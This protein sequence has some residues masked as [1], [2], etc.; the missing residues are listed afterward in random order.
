MS[1]WNSLVRSACVGVAMACGAAGLSGCASLPGAG[2]DLTSGFLGQS[3]S[4][5]GK[6][7]SLPELK[8]AHL[9]KPGDPDTTVAYAR[10]LKTSGRP[11]EA[12][13]LV[14]GAAASQPDN[15][16]LVVEQGLL[17]LELGQT[18]KAQHALLRASPD[19]KDWKILSGLGVAHAGVGQHAKAQEY[20]QRALEI[21]PRN[22]TVLNN[23]ALSYILDKKVDKGRELLQEASA[24]GAD[25]PQIARNLEL[26][27]A[28]KGGKTKPANSPALNPA[29]ATAAIARG[30]ALAPAPTAT[31]AAKSDRPSAKPTGD[32]K[33]ATAPV[34]L[35]AAPSA[36]AAPE[37]ISSDPA[38][39]PAEVSPVAALQTSAPVEKAS[40]EPVTPKVLNVGVPLAGR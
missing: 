1:R 36:S 33:P 38:T 23:L 39:G 31:A 11:K 17:A 8:Q 6:P 12:L 29:V 18:A 25:K 2:L 26:A 40:L 21:S 3:A 34:A 19:T 35:A 20:F 24:A 15:Q 14:E 4:E 13:A 37:P 30:P 7:K 27:M 22:P 28:L 16:Q 10:G 5:P 9:E 32:A